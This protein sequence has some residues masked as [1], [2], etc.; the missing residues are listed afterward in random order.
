MDAQ[1]VLVVEDDAALSELVTE[2]LVDAGYRPLTIR[3][4]ALIAETVDRWQPRAVLLDGELHAT[5]ESRSWRDAAAIRRAHPG[6]PVVLFTADM[7]AVTEARLGRSYRS[8]V[9]GFAGIVAKP[10]AVED[11]LATMK[12]AVDVSPGTDVMAM[13]VHELRQPLAVIRGQVQLA[14]RHV[15]QDP[16]S[17]RLAMDHTIAQVDRMAALIDELLDHARLTAD[18]F[19]LEVGVLD[20]AEAVAAAI[21]TYD[22]DAI[23]RISYAPP[24]GAAP[25][26][27]DPARIAQIIDNMLSNALKYSAAGSP[28]EVSLTTDGVEAQVRV[29]DRGVGVPEAER[30]LLFAPFYRSTRTRDVRG[31]GLGLHLSKRLAERHGGQL[32]LDA[33]S[34]AGSE[35]VFALPIAHGDP[36]P[37]ARSS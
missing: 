35:F 16:Q 22:H 12:A 30:R 29:V 24:S 8:R 6:L 32:W 28:V 4:H 1:N 25:V 27:G 7:A 19:S 3:D 13:I 31:T 9:A 17:E 20:L 33:T 2:V 34:E 10:F 15:G 18:G 26:Y 21:A 37:R 11:L 23:S 14:R 36:A 5:G